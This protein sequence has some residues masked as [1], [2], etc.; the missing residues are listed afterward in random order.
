MKAIL[1]LAVV[2]LAVVVAAR[3]SQDAQALNPKKEPTDVGAACKKST[4]CLGGLRCDHTSKTCQ[5]PC[6][7]SGNNCK[8]DTE[9]CSG[10]CRDGVCLCY[11]H[12]ASCMWGD[13]CCDGSCNTE[14]V[15]C[16]QTG[17]DCETNSHCCSGVCQVVK[18]TKSKAAALLEA[19]ADTAADTDATPAKAP[20]KPKAK[21]MAP[22]APAKQCCSDFGQKCGDA[23]PCCA[24]YICHDAVGMCTLKSFKPE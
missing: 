5:R 6:A 7:K 19:D 24:P 20:A 18:T 16:R 13:Q 14:K 1:V 21:K 4:D 3:D 2:V 23:A 12:G 11:A 22:A 17:T 10:S 8:A 15:C 9:C